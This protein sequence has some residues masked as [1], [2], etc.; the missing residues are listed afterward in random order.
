MVWL[1]IPVKAAE[2]ILSTW[3]NNG[4]WLAFKIFIAETSIGTVIICKAIRIDKSHSEVCAESSV[5]ELIW[6][7]IAVI[8]AERILSTWSNNGEWLADKVF[9]AETSIGTVII[10]KATRIDNSRRRENDRR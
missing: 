4:V 3:S 8:A 2:R 5:T 9:I 7:A 10:C 6:L 1:A